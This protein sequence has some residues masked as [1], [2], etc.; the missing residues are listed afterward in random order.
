V[1]SVALTQSP[2]GGGH[3]HAEAE[4]GCTAGLL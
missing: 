2:Q 3:H 1:G 4:R